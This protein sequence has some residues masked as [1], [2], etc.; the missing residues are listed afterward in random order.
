[1][2]ARLKRNTR[3]RSAQVTP[4]AIRLFRQGFEML[5]GPHDPYELRDLKIAL[6]AA[7]SRSKFRSCPLDRDPKSL[8]GCDRERVEVALELRALLLKEI[9]EG[10]LSILATKDTWR[11]SR[12]L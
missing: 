11:D 6:A 8:L 7:L 2:P 1:M 5:R 12:Q 9:G 4:E 10:R 3:Y